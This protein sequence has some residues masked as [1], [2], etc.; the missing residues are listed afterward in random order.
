MTHQ[1]TI[2]LWGFPVIMC[3]NTKKS[4]HRVKHQILVN[5]SMM[6][7]KQ[8]A[9]ENLSWL[10]ILFSLTTLCNPSMTW[11]YC[12]STP[13]LDIENF[14]ED[15]ISVMVVV[16]ADKLWSIN[17]KSWAF[18]W[19]MSIACVRTFSTAVVHCFYIS[20]DDWPVIF[21]VVIDVIMFIRADNG[22]LSMQCD[23]RPCL[24]LTHWVID[25]TTHVNPLTPRQ[26][27]SYKASCARPG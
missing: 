8:T 17:Y 7:Q 15:F 25:P 10:R 12:L 3:E 5:L 1:N 24:S 26:L 16:F 19:T 23:P 18:D 27:L 2:L 22:P 4:F 14:W 13:V 6:D 21:T 11:L 9:W 20:S